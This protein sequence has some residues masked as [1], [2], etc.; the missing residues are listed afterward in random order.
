MLY[1][2]SKV[3]F[4]VCDQILSIVNHVQELALQ[5]CNIKEQW[6]QLIMSGFAL[7]HEAL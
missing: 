5:L 3:T 6:I 4:V 7:F 2:D 1:H